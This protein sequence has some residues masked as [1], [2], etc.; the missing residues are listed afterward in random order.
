MSTNSENEKYRSLYVVIF[1]LILIFSLIFT[2][3]IYYFIRHKKRYYFDASGRKFIVSSDDYS[4]IIYKLMEIIQFDDRELLEKKVIDCSVGILHIMNENNQNLLHLCAIHGSKECMFYL[5]N[6]ETVFNANEKDNF[7]NTPLGY[8]VRY[9][10]EDSRRN[11]EMF[12][13]LASRS[14]CSEYREMFNDWQLEL[15]NS[16]FNK[17]SIN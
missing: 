16:F 13:M 8:L 4:N 1:C 10:S 12:M 11:R 5:L 17:I 7:T 14:N 6:F 3:L 2:L 9:H 15:Y